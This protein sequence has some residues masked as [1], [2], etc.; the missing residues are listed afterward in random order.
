MFKL[1][2]MTDYAITVM[3]S[4]SGVTQA[5]SAAALSDQT[6]IPEP[7]VAKVL[8]TLT[9][10][11]LVVSMRGVAGGYSVARKPADISVAE[12]VEAMDGP[13][14]I[15]S[16]IEGSNEVCASEGKCPAKGKWAPVNASIRA[17]LDAVR[18]TDLGAPK[19]RVFQITSREENH[20]GAS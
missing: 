20:V 8:K 19:Q 16:C 6:G 1:G 18:L 7:T 17:A 9:R 2:K 14:A 4:L 5:R 12:I 15:V 11:G 3:V 13:I 10:A